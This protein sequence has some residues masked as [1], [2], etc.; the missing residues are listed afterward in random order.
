VEPARSLAVARPE[1]VAELDPKRNDHLNVTS[2]G[3]ASM[4][5][6]GWRCGQCQHSWETTVASRAGGTGCPACWTRRRGATFSVVPPQRSLA[7]RAPTVAHELHPNRNPPELDP[8][9]LGARSSKSVWWLCGVCAHEWQARV[10][11]RAT[12]TRCPIC[13]RD[14]R[15]TAAA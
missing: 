10:V 8:G 13:A 15:R 5:K 2:L 6:V 14:Q 4:R 9:T 11:D 7:H 1:L 12:G 3:I